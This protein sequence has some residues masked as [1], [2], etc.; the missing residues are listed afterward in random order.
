M[1]GVLVAVFVFVWLMEIC[2]LASVFIFMS[3]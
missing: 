2:G 1:K 3:C